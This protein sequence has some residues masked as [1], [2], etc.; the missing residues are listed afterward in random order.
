MI[1]PQPAASIR[2]RVRSIIA[3][4]QQQI[5]SASAISSPGA[6]PPKHAE[7]HDVVAQ[8][9]E[10]EAGND[11]HATGQSGRVRRRQP[12]GSLINGQGEAAGA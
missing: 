5:A 8:E 1:K 10:V 3:T 11:R 7:A 9:N 4:S 6:A 12:F 2:L